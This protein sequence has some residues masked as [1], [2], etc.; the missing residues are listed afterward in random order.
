MFTAESDSQ[1]PALSTLGR[2]LARKRSAEEH[3]ANGPLGNGFPVGIVRLHSYAA[4]PDVP[5]AVYDELKARGHEV[6]RL[7][8][9]GMSGCATAVMIDPATGN[10]FAAGDP[11][12]D[13]Y[14]I[15]Y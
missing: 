2:A 13:C 15:A 10:R 11:R 7:P 3:G 6:R 1:R 5:V 14:A 8:R 4:P 9:F 12:R